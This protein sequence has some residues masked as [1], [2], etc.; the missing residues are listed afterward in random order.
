ML[1]A[2]ST[3]NSYGR[4]SDSASLGVLLLVVLTASPWAVFPL[5]IPLSSSEGSWKVYV[6]VVRVLKS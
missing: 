2:E 4:R 5:F 6:T 3:D 1:L